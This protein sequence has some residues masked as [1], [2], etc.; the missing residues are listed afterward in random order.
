M[1]VSGSA[2]KVNDVIDLEVGLLRKDLPR[3]LQYVNFESQVEPLLDAIQRVPAALAPR[4]DSVRNDEDL[5]PRGKEKK[6]Q[7]ARF[8]SLAKLDAFESSELTGTTGLAKIVRDFERQVNEAANAQLAR[9]KDPTERLIAELRY[10][11]IRRSAPGDPLV[12][13]LAYLSVTDPE[14]IAAF[15]TAPMQFVTGTSGQPRLIPYIS[16]D[17]VR[18]RIMTRAQEL[19]P[20]E[21][22]AKLK[23]LYLVRQTIAGLV[24]SARRAIDEAIPAE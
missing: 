11:E 2:A 7:T 8:D 21:L 3:K 10:A 18:D 23:E 17:R 15:E 6:L 14:V 13:E 9:P 19:A 24:Q 4:I 20:A 12:R 1:H 16:P 22:V 5:A